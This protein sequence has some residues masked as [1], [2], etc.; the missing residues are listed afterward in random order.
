MKSKVTL[1][2]PIAQLAELEV[3]KLYTFVYSS[4]CKIHGLVCS[5]ETPSMLRSGTTQTKM[6]VVL[7]IDA[8]MADWS[9]S[10]EIGSIWKLCKKYNFDGHF[11]S[12]HGS[13]ALTQ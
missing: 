4:G 12:F 3:G 2:A 5:G 8:T 9:N 1:S 6:F 7:N 10:D 11:H 13:I